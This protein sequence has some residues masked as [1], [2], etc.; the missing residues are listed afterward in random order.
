MTSGGAPEFSACVSDPANWLT[1]RA[2]AR[3]SN[4]TVRNVF[5][6]RRWANASD[7]V[8]IPPVFRV[9]STTSTSV[10]ALKNA[11]SVFSCCKAVVVL[12]GASF[13]MRRS[14][15]LTPF[16]T[17]VPLKKKCDDCVPR[18]VTKPAGRL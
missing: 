6:I 2:V 8:R 11:I 12:G 18:R 4:P 3:N 1:L 17:Y 16:D 9:M 10:F 13:G 5:G 7:V 15:I 14:P